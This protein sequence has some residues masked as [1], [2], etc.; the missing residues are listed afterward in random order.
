MST[1]NSFPRGTLSK[2]EAI[3]HRRDYGWSL[4]VGTEKH[5]RGNKSPAAHLLP[6]LSYIII[7]V[8]IVCITS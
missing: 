2:S 8:M 1:G 5:L 7:K 4:D 6:L 3:P